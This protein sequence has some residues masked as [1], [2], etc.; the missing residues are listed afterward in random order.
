[1]CCAGGALVLTLPT[2]GSSFPGGHGGPTGV[3]AELPFWQRG[4]GGSQVSVVP[5][6]PYEWGWDLPPGHGA[7][8]AWPVSPTQHRP[9]P[10]RWVWALTPTGPYGLSPG[11]GEGG[12][13]L[14]LG[15][16]DHPAGTRR[17]GTASPSH[18]ILACPLGPGI[19]HSPQPH[20]ILCQPR[21]GI[22]A[23]RWP[24]F[25]GWCPWPPASLPTALGYG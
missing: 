9:Q 25:G 4:R 16:P 11:E 22:M 1:M 12:S 10:L 17:D 8:H 13:P 19:H 20:P 7:W 21:L 14:A 18:S 5:G 3:R 6:I 2:A 24:L 23:P 15:C